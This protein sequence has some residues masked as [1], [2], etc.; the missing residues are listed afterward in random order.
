MAIERINKDWQ[1]DP[2]NTTTDTVSSMVIQSSHYGGSFQAVTVK[3]SA[4]YPDALGGTPTR[5]FVEL[6]LSIDVSDLAGAKPIAIYDNDS[7]ATLTRVT[8]VPSANEYRVPPVASERNNVIE[9]NS[10]QAGNTIEFNYY[11]MNTVLNAATLDYL[12]NN[13]VDMKSVTAS[14]AITTT[15]GYDVFIC[16]PSTTMITMTLPDLASS[17]GRR[18]KIKCI[19]NGIIKIIRAGSDVIDDGIKN[20]TAVYLHSKGDSMVLLATSSNWL[21]DSV[22]DVI[23]TGWISH[24]DWSNVELGT[25]NIVVDNGSSGALGYELG[26]TVSDTVHSGK[27]IDITDNADGTGTIIVYSCSSGAFFTNNNTLT[28]NNSSASALVNGNTK[29][30]NAKFYHGNNIDKEYYTV[31]A[32]YSASSTTTNIGA[33]DISQKSI[34]SGVNFGT[35]CIDVDGDSFEFYTAASGFIV[36]SPTTGTGVNATGEKFYNIKYKRKI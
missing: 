32:F 7:S 9:V 30:V 1:A 23:L 21:M 13:M 31:C 34:P 28:G 26:E 27:V 4:N 15:D 16:D 5:Y 33:F 24:S 19:A 3:S 10:G 2:W 6:P 25:I 14:T 12:R 11:G 20:Q 36:I 18:I 35:E 29:N 8:G 22:T 17:I